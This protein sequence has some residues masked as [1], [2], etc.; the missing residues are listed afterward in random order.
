MRHDKGAGNGL[1]H[2]DVFLHDD[3]VVPQRG[4]VGGAMSRSHHDRFTQEIVPHLDAAFSLARWL[5]HSDHDAEDIVQESL[6]KALRF[7]PGYKGLNGHGWLLAIVRN[8]AYA[9]RKR[10]YAEDMTVMEPDAPGSVPAEDVSPDAALIRGEHR[11]E[12]RRVLEK[13]PVHLR[14][15]LILREVEG[16]SYKS[17]AEVIQSPTGTVMSRLARAREQLSS[18]LSTALRDG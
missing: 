17:I 3:G 2:S 4:P 10:Q 5:S 6:V 18:L 1:P 14:E 7:M 12:V 13:L 15:V 11:Q 8:T 9:W 16:L